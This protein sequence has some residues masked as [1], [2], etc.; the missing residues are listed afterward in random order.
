[1][2]FSRDVAL[3]ACKIGYRTQDQ[4]KNVNKRHFIGKGDLTWVSLYISRLTSS[5]VWLIAST[6]AR[7][8]SSRPR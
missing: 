3:S 4:R 5:D 8:H 7:P 2:D 6:L 1:M